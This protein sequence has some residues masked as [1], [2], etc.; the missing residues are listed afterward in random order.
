VPLF[1][2]GGEVVKFTPGPWATYNASCH[3]ESTDIV[4]ADDTNDRICVTCP[5]STEGQELANAN[6]IAAAPD[7]YEALVKAN[8][9]IGKLAGW[10]GHDLS[11]MEA[12]G[13]DLIPAALARAVTGKGVE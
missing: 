13:Y 10:S 6:L 1:I 12:Y 2:E 3:S 4:V 11:E 7:L 8:Y 5:Q 9:I